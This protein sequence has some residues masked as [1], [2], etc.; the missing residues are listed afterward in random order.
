MALL[1]KG[2]FPM[3]CQ[4]HNPQYPTVDVNIADRVWQE[5]SKHMSEFSCA[6]LGNARDLSK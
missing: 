5:M 1:G 2:N 3:M 6:E 4:W